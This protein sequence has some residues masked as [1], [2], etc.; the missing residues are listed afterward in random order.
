M[1]DRRADGRFGMAIVTLFD[2]IIEMLIQ[3][4]FTER[5]NDCTF[6]DHSSILVH[7]I[8]CDIQLF[9]KVSGLCIGVFTCS[10]MST[11]QRY[12]HISTK[13][14]IFQIDSTQFRSQVLVISC[15][16]FQYVAIL[17]CI[18]GENQIEIVN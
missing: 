14:G 12:F 2:C 15:F 1:M 16:S 9:V 7:T 18:K 4:A 13:T 8:E 17:L 10:W 6:V 3:F 11:T 5:T